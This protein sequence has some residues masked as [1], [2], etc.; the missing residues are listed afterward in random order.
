VIRDHAGQFAQAF[1][2][3]FTNATIE[4]VPLLT[5]IVLTIL[6]PRWS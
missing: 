1:D 4:A 3:V 6:H 2:A 5:V